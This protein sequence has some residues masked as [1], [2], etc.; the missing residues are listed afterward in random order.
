V[1]AVEEKRLGRYEVRE[2]VDTF[3]VRRAA[4]TWALQIGFP[5]RVAEELVLVVSEL[6]T[7]IL[8]YGRHGFITM[9]MLDD[10]E[11]G[12]GI[13]FEARDFGPPF[14]DFSLAL[15]DRHD[16]KGPILPEA[17]SISMGLGVGLGTVVRLTDRVEHQ[18]LGDGKIVRAIRFVIRAGRRS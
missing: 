17:R 12:P 1:Q 10:E 3:A 13:R 14:H 2:A 15:L 7:N 4:R 8:K 18:P 9:D 11:R 6:A 16:D 5:L